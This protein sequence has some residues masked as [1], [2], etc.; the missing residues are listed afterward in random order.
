[1]MAAMMKRRWWD[2]P[3]LRECKQAQRY[4]YFSGP[5]FLWDP[6]NPW[7]DRQPS[8]FDEGISIKFV[9]ER[10]IPPTTVKV[11]P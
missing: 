1:M 11:L 4:S 6:H 3:K 2:G 8:D 10:D 9:R 7:P 5:F